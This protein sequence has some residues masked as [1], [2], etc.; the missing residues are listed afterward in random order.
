M[1]RILAIVKTIKNCKECVYARTYPHTLFAYCENPD[2]PV[3]I[4]ES[5]AN[6]ISG[7]GFPKW[8]PLK[9]DSDI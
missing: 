4:K 3:E 2:R 6:T 5:G 1:K 7:K 9:R 8:C